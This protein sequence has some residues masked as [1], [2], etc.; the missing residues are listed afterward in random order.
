L[1]AGSRGVNAALLAY[2][3]GVKRCVLA[4][5]IRRSLAAADRQVVVAGGK[6][7]EVARI[8]I[9][10]RGGGGWGRRLIDFEPK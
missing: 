3:H 6:A 2:G 7:I 5:L 8:K 1:R 9:T 10:G 4:G